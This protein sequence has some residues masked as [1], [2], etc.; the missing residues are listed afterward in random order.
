M[1]SL[2]SRS[3]LF[4]SLVAAVPL[5]TG[6]SGNGCAPNPVVI[7]N[8]TGG[9]STTMPG[10]GGGTTTTCAPTDCGAPPPTPL[11]PGGETAQPVCELQADD[12]CGW[13]V[14]PCA[15]PV[16]CNT[17]ACGPAPALA[18]LC[19]DGTTVTPICGQTA[20]NMC[21]WVFPPCP[22]SACTP[23][24]CGPEPQI[25]GECPGGGSVYPVCGPSPTGCHWSVPACPAPCTASECGAMPN[26]E[27]PFCNGKA[28]V[29]QCGRDAQNQCSWFYPPCI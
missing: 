8:D 3:L 5:L 14:P 27:P 22:T 6:A 21:G 2:S 9:G 15:P 13:T 23:A 20:Q 17:P 26:D 4:L 1:P 18:Q 24:E 7:G 11:C 25:V 12:A 16:P 28:E 10:T 29:I 19:P